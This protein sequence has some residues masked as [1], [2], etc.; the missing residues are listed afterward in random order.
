IR[1]TF[2]LTIQQITMAA[3]PARNPLIT[4]RLWTTDRRS[5]PDPQHHAVQRQPDALT[6]PLRVSRYIADRGHTDKE[7][8]RWSR[9]FHQIY[10][11]IK[12]PRIWASRQPDYN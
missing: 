8:L 9:I 12:M 6:M 4:G 11:K 5:D 3:G 2:L 1:F 7:P 10:K